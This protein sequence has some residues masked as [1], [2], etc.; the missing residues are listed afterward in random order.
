MAAVLAFSFGCVADT[1]NDISIIADGNTLSFDVPP[2]VE[3]GR[4]LV[5]L[6]AIFEALDADVKWSG[7]S[8]TILATRAG[9]QITL[10][11]G[12]TNAYINSKPAQ[13]EVPAKVIQDR[14]LV[15]LRFVGESL[16]AKVVW[17]DSTRTITITSSRT[18]SK[19]MS[20]H[21]INVGQGDA[22]LIQT[23][24][25]KVMLIDG[26]PRSAGEKVVSYLK[27]AGV[28]S[29]DILVATHPHEDHIGGLIDVLNAFTVKKIYD[30]GYPHTSKTYENYLTLIEEK[31][32]NF[33]KAHGFNQINIDPAISVTILHPC[34]T[35]D[36]INNNS[37]VLKVQYDNVGFMFTGDAESEAEAY[38]MEKTDDATLKSTVIKV[39][40]H[41]SHTSTSRQF[42]DKVAP[43]IAIISV[44]AGNDY[45]HPNSDILQ[46]IHNTGAQ[47]YRTDLNGD[48]II[49]T[50]GNTYKVET[51]KSS[52]PV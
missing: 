22:I 42:I 5:P 27:K 45:G 10:K 18:N 12:D 16:G 30:S 47:I 32:I 40:H 4:T 2:V 44:G 38:F 26:G 25:G 11:I 36:G 46:R 29:I 6:R 49:C 19:D 52:N 7:E 41:G 24:N 3:N 23:P 15:P 21:F 33:N 20:V 35:M 34:T 39:G 9:M 37:V 50:N 13:L 28:S 43:Q 17:E 8:Q 51:N 48:I 14:T 31:N 1:T